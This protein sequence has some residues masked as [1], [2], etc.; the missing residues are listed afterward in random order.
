MLS[1]WDSRSALEGAGGSASVPRLSSKGSWLGSLALVALGSRGSGSGKFEF[2]MAS[3]EIIQVFRDPIPW[4]GGSRVKLTDS[5]DSFRQ[6]MTSGRIGIVSVYC[7]NVMSSSALSL[8]LESD[9]N[10]QDETEGKSAQK[11]KSRPYA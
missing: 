11:D 3:L 6:R 8:S 1:S 4:V 2:T 10:S 5:S 7:H 9:N